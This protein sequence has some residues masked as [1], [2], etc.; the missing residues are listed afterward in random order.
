MDAKVV[1][2]NSAK[3]RQEDFSISVVDGAEAINEDGATKMN[4]SAMSKCYM[5]TPVSSVFFGTNRPSSV[6][7]E[8]NVSVEESHPVSRNALINRVSFSITIALNQINTTPTSSPKE[9]D[10]KDNGMEHT[11][12]GGATASF[13]LLLIVLVFCGWFCKKY[14]CRQKNHPNSVNEALFDI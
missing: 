9:T 5:E 10:E 4:C 12:I 3:L 6:V 13:V 2:L 8:G 11:L 14:S 7:V 1:S